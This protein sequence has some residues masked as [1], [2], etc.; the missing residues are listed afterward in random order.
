VLIAPDPDL[1]TPVAM[2]DLVSFLFDGDPKVQYGVD[3]GTIDPVRV[4]VLRGAVT[5]TAGDPLPGVL[6]SVKD[7]LEYGTTR[8]RED[9]RYDLA[10]NGGGL[11]HLEF[12]LEDHIP[13]QRTVRTEWTA[14][15]DVDD[16]AL[17]S[18][19]PMAT[20]VDFA[21]PMQVHAATLKSDVDG[22][23]QAR[24]FFRQGT[25]ATAVL[26]DDST[27]SLPS[28]TVRATEFTV[29]AQ[30]EAA[31]PLQ[32]PLNT[33]Y[34]YAIEYTVEEAE[35]IGA[36]RVDFDQPV[37]TYNENFLGYEVGEVVPNGYVDR[38]RGVW[39]N[40]DH[41]GRIVEILDIQGG[42]AILDLDGDGLED[43][44]TAHAA[45][46]IDVVEREALGSVYG[47][48]E[49]LWR[50]P[51]DH[52]STYDSNWGWGPKCEC[53]PAT[54]CPC[55][56]S[57]DPHV[58]V[59]ENTTC[60]DG[61]IVEC[62]TTSL[63]E[64]VPLAGTGLFLDYRSRRQ[65]G[66]KANNNV[67]ANS[68][69]RGEALP[70]TNFQLRVDLWRGR[71]LVD[72]K[73]YPKSSTSIGMDVDLSALTE[74]TPYGQAQQGPQLGQ[75]CVSMIFPA[76]RYTGVMQSGGGNFGY[77]GNGATISVVGGRN[78]A[79][80]V[81]KCSKRFPIGGWS[82]QN[83]AAGLGG[84]TLSAHHT[85]SS[86]TGTLLMGDGSRRT[87]QNLGAKI[88]DVAQ[89]GWAIDVATGP[90]GTYYIYGG[91]GTWIDAIDPDGVRTRFAGTGAAGFSGDGGPAT[92][93]QL[94]V[95]GRGIAV[96]PDGS[97]VFGDGARIR[98]VDPSGIIDTVAG[99]GVNAATYGQDVDAV[100][101]DIR[102]PQ[103]L[104]AGLDGSIYWT[105]SSGSTGA[106]SVIRQLTTAGTLRLIASDP[107]QCTFQANP[108]E[109]GVPAI[110]WCIRQAKGLA[111][112]GEN[113]IYFS[114]YRTGGSDFGDVYRI[115]GTGAIVHLGAGAWG[116]AD[117]SWSPDADRVYYGYR[118]DD[119]GWT[120]GV[121]F[122]DIGAQVFE[123]FAGTGDGELVDGGLA[124]NSKLE[125]QMQAV[126]AGPRGEVLV[127]QSD[128]TELRRVRR[129]LPEF[130]DAD[131]IVASEDGSQVYMFD[132][133]GR[134]LRTVDS[135]TKVVVWEF[136]YDADGWLETATDRNGD[137]VTLHRNADGV[138]HSVEAEDGQITTLEVTDGY[139]TSVE[140]P[141]GERVEI[142]YDA[143]GLMTSFRKPRGNTS[144]FT[145]DAE[146]RLER[147]TNAAGGFTDLA[148]TEQDR[149][150]SVVVGSALGRTYTTNIESTGEQGGEVRTTTHR[151][152]TETVAVHA[153]DGGSLTTYPDGTT[154]EVEPRSDPRFPDQS[155]TGTTTVA[156]PSGRVSTTST[157]RFVALA[158]P[159]DPLSVTSQ[160]EVVEV[161]GRTGTFVYDDGA[162]TWTSA[163]PEG[164]V[165]TAELDGG[166]RP[167]RVTLGDLEP[168]RITYDSR[169]RPE[170]VAQGTG[171]DERVMTYTYDAV[172]GFL[173]AV[174]DPLGREVSFT[175]DA[176]GRV[177][178]QELPDSE[179]IGF[180]YDLNGNIV[181]IVP[182]GKPGHGFAHNEVDEP[183][184]YTPPVVP[185]VAAPETNYIYNL[186][187][188][189][190]AVQRPDA[191]TV[192]PTY[193][194]VSGKLVTVEIGRGSFAY[195]YS[196]TTGQLVSATDPDGGV[197]SYGYD[198]SLVTDE[199]YVGSEFSA[200]VHREYDN[201]FRVVSRDIDGGEVVAYGYDGDN[202]LTS[203][204][205]ETLEYDGATGL[206]ESTTV[207]E[208]RMEMLYNG[209]GEPTTIR[210]TDGV[211]GLLYE[212]VLERDKLGRIVEKRETTLSGG[213]VT[214]DYGYD[215]RGRL[216]TVHE[217]GTLSRSWSYDANGNRSETT[218][219]SNKVGVY[220]AQD[221]MMAYGDLSFTYGENGEMTSMTDTSSGEVTTY[222]YDEMGNLLEVVL[223]GGDVIEYEH[224]ARNRRVGK[225]VNGVFE[226]G[227]VYKDQLNPIAEVDA[228]GT[229]VARFV[230]G[231]RGHVPDLVVRGGVTYRVVTDHLGSVRAVVDA[232]TG[233]VVQEVDYD[234]WGE[235][236]GD[237]NPAWQPF[238]F[239]GG[240]GDAGT[241]LVRFGARDYVGSLA[242]WSARDPIGFRGGS[243]NLYRYAHNSPVLLRDASGLTVYRC[244]RVAD[245]PL[246]DLLE[247]EHHW[248]V[249]DTM[250][251][252]LGAC[253]GGVPGQGGSDLPLV[254]TCYNDHSGQSQ[255]D[256]VVCY[257]VDDVHEGCVD[258]ILSRSGQVG[259]WWPGYECQA[260]M[261]DI[262]QTCTLGP[263]PQ[264]DSCRSLHC[265]LAEHLRDLLRSEP[266]P[267]PP[268]Y[269]FPAF[270]PK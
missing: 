215:L 4:A 21:D 202:L 188:Q 74:T 119:G 28:I 41:E 103:D 205:G 160:T 213:T 101:T 77:N 225:S 241:G 245:L 136:G 23:R 16:V 203:A 166:G 183:T 268:S 154:M 234:A 260:E 11:F 13:S 71:H 15:S 159:E 59:D 72:S 147:D 27:V 65:S 140:N 265:V 45:L 156:T 35:A 90:D 83:L 98:R 127:L 80:D 190:E 180:E 251:V 10:V 96:T 239:A 231:A 149:E 60:E 216:T 5:D 244:S 112:D 131:S 139:L 142:D 157:Q 267:G 196:A 115:D 26:P 34:T 79:F 212:E 175:R 230:Y 235:V 120:A 2:Y 165:A 178:S 42:M 57:A 102:P 191:K 224:D 55:E 223:P 44:A 29:G 133:R 174:T 105:E 259:N 257:P 22:S 171:G 208:V 58:E 64:R 222:D 110:G 130:V 207:G 125:G 49:Q 153:A 97:V 52:F 138:I 261:D 137:V 7:H 78:N 170:T 92:A 155:L 255:G 66:Y 86:H 226:R 54:T 24:V 17:V 25:N 14:F 228:S 85:Y 104:A 82:A 237:T 186:D 48:G 192:D 179:V 220:D 197:L 173:N 201:D 150:V 128:G 43:D 187:R 182:P 143:G 199:G 99:T 37:V 132:A 121:G 93:A 87:V 242:R 264:P 89:I 18:Y 47:V 232:S 168:L 221:R 12:A 219:G 84:W 256:D 63:G 238:G 163:S 73:I 113:N 61:S 164:R 181:E 200:N 198:G 107:S 38:E 193:D 254:P 252:G 76:V 176:V 214:Y 158:N 250:E 152:G 100:T 243:G 227:W 211:N 67:R 185:F 189:V 266:A 270:G 177:L 68:V 126:A 161:N 109:A 3:P 253:G 91:S 206:L 6:V 114:D 145:W 30:G 233:V 1:Q 40:G 19:D 32:M 36:V 50:V 146:G 247:L 169:G 106:R 236:L 94:K 129:A 81:M 69:L 124:L 39:V 95:G 151:D 195:D 134:H 258:A 62:D 184:S 31:M 172:T 117:L 116:T 194:P 20:L 144:T 56:G 122:Y 111:V 204:G 9:G 248:L 218:P 217:G 88:E 210:Y 249:T 70:L 33:A 51:V 108:D 123:R 148:R 46:D 135:L 240:L 262:L 53:P 263:I 209:F 246:N 8:S 229:V 118:F 167:T 141:A 162:R 75:V 269:P